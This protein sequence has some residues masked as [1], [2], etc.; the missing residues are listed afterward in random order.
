MDDSS[1][2]RRD[3]LKCSATT[4]GAIGAS[5]VVA[6]PIAGA[7]E[8]EDGQTTG[9]L[10]QGAR[11]YNDGYQG[12]HLNRVAFPLGGIGAGMVCLEERLSVSDPHGP[13]TGCG[14]EE[15]PEIA[16][17]PGLQVENPLDR[18]VAPGRTSDRTRT[19][20]TDCG[21]ARRSGRDRP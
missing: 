20:R 7:I 19:R 1:V 6:P 11:T 9:S 18:V 2:R 10:Q 12:L 14:G 5:G 17:D 4:L 8:A 15:T 3:F 13:I 16:R 21:L